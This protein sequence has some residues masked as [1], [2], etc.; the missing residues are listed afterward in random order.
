MATTHLSGSSGY[1]S[2][3]LPTP[4]KFA[5]GDVVAYKPYSPECLET[6]LSEGRMQGPATA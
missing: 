3:L 5:V 4:Q 1:P 2:E 6:K